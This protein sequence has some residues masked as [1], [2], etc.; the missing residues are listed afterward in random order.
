MKKNDIGE[1]EIIDLLRLLEPKKL[2]K[3][4]SEKLVEIVRQQQREKASGQSTF[5][6]YFGRVVIMILVGT[7]LLFFID[8]N[9]LGKDFTGSFGLIAFMLGVGVIL[10]FLKKFKTASAF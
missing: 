5:E 6:R 4:S 7:N 8:L 9:P 3:E 10:V 1:E 2:S